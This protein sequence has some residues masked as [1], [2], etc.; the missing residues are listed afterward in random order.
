MTRAAPRLAGV[1][2][3]RSW[4]VLC[5]GRHGLACREEFDPR[6]AAKRRRGASPRSVAAEEVE[7]RG[8]PCAGVGVVG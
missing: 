2:L 7:G 3:Q 1:E 6:E 5:H 8:A 4:R